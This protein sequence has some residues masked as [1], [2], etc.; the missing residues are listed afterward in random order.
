MRTLFQSVRWRP[1]RRPA[2]SLART[3]LA[4]V[5]VLLALASVLGVAAGRMFQE[6]RGNASSPASNHAEVIAQGVASLPATDVAWRVTRASAPREMNRPDDRD[7][8]FVLADAD[9]LQ[10]VDIETGVQNRLAA[11]EAQ[12]VRDGA[13]LLR[14]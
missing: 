9:A 13:W 5:A 10:L 2:P 8:G 7:L 1:A 14:L 12:F 4:A 11:G 6:Q 3:A